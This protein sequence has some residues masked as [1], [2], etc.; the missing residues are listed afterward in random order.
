M[1]LT[2]TK[3]TRHTSTYYHDTPLSLPHQTRY[4]APHMPSLKLKIIL[5]ICL[6]ATA[7]GAVALG[8]LFLSPAIEEY[9]SQTRF[10]SAAWKAAEGQQAGIRIHMID[11]LLQNFQLVG[12]T[13]AEV[14]SL[15]GKPEKT[16]YFSDYEYVYWLG[17]ERGFISIDSEC[18]GLKFKDE[19]VSEAK[20]L[21]D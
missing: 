2:V 6:V 1:S 16:P 14:D 9:A 7:V 20:L 12:M 10:E 11:D 18:L 19:I 5:S 3:P 17:P 13:R 15:L 8:F 4:N 21:R